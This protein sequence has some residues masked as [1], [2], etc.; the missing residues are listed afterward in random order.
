MRK[1]QKVTKQVPHSLDLLHFTASHLELLYLSYLC[2]Q[3]F[4]FFKVMS[5][6]ACVFM[7]SHIKLWL[8][9]QKSVLF[10][11]PDHPRAHVSYP[12]KR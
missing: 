11:L 10:S 12:I 4:F 9:W 8:I 5:N 7:F 6:I 1:C 3:V 2:T